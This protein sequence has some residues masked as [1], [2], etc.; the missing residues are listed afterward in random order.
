[1][2]KTYR[3]ILQ[4]LYILYTGLIDGWLSI[5]WCLAVQLSDNI[6]KKRAERYYLT[7]IYL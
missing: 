3:R 5:T 7:P 2:Q 4:S 1:M 6:Q